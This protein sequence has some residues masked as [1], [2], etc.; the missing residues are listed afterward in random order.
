VRPILISFVIVCLSLSSVAG[1][2]PA[3]DDIGARSSSPVMTNV[4]DLAICAWNSEQ[5]TARR[6]VAQYVSQMGSDKDFQFTFRRTDFLTCGGNSALQIAIS[7]PNQLAGL[8][9]RVWVNQAARCV[10]RSKQF[11]AAAVYSD[12]AKSQ[13]STADAKLGD[14]A[15]ALMALA[16]GKKLPANL[17]GSVAT[18][19]ESVAAWINSGFSG[20]VSFLNELGYE[21]KRGA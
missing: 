18:C 2:E 9:Q 13:Y 11:S 16:S 12:L 7:Q 14:G 3:L 5:S 15:K 10:A 6:L 19:D 8:L 4:R 21:E 1:A 17:M 20:A